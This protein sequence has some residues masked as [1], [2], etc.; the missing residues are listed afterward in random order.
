MV[1]VERAVTDVPIPT[2]F[3]MV[4][5]CDEAT[6]GRLVKI[7]SSCVLPSLQDATEKVNLKF[8]ASMRVREVQP[9]KMLVKLLDEVTPVTLKFG[10][11]VRAEQF[12]NMAFISVI[13]PV[14]VSCIFTKDRQP[15]NALFALVTD[16]QSKEGINCSASQDRN[17]FC[18]VVTDAVFIRGID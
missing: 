18:I 5:V 15:L 16:V 17:A 9:L 10:T 8:F 1:V 14:F 4:I 12:C 11:L 7:S 6:V 13:A 2:L 3:D